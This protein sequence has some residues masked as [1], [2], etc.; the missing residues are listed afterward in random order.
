MNDNNDFGSFIA[1]FIIGGLVGAAMS[2]LLAPQSGLET[3]S[4]I[5]DRGSEIRDRA[6]ETGQDVR[7]R[8]NQSLEELRVRVDELSAQTRSSLAELQHR[9]S[10][11]ENAVEDFGS[12]A[13]G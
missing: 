3:R 5:R 1:G 11:A 4:Q 8:A 13:V 12:E 10:K 9:I 2:L 7:E 6:Y